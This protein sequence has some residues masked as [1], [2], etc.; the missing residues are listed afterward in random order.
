MLVCTRCGML[1]NEGDLKYVT[2]PHGETHLDTVCHCG[3]ELVEAK[4][5]KVCGKW[6]DSTDLHEVCECCLYEFETVET[7]I[8]IGAENTEKRDINGFFADILTTDMINS[9]LGKW[10]EEN[11]TDHSRSVIDYL[12]DD[13]MYYSQYLEEKYGE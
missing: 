2:E 4:K 8:N 9:I 7:A 12:E 5:C 3:G 13:K 6:F 11:I 1:V 10:V